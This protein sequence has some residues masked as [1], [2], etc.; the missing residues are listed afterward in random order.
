M[1]EN[2][3][4]MQRQDLVCTISLNRPDKSNAL[5]LELLKQ[6]IEVLNATNDDPSV[7]VIVLRGAG[8]KIFSAGYDLVQLPSTAREWSDRM[9]EGGQTLPEEDLLKVAVESIINHRCPAIAMIYGP[10]M[11]S[12]CDLIAGCDL[13]LA[14]DTARF[15]IPAVKRG[16]LYHPEGIQRLIDL[17]GVAGAK[18]T[19]LTGDLIDAQRAKEIGLVNQVVAAKD[20]EDATYSLASRM[21]R[22][23]PLAVTGSKVLISKLLKKRSLSQEDEKESKALMARC[24]GSYDFQEGMRAFAEK[25]AP[26]FEGR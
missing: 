22:N 11:G 1:Q 20:L 7:R 9:A 19:L 18:E 13:R 2:M 3:I 24:F 15:G 21:A 5:C 25:R 23:A 14:A 12:S 16:V 26:K 6:L 8:D 10:V 4:T 17:V